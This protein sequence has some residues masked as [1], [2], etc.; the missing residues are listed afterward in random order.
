GGTTWTTQN[1]G[2]PTVPTGLPSDIEVGRCVHK[3]VLDPARPGVLYQQFHGGVFVS[4]D[5]AD[6]W[7]SIAD[8]L[9]GDFGFPM[10]ITASGDLFVMPLRS[11]EHRM[12][13]DGKLRVWR[14]RNQGRSWQALS[15]GLPNSPQYVGV[16]R[17][18]MA[19]D[20]LDP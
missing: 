17:D 12:M 2:L 6:S 13:D 1:K 8:G 18:A 10:V 9:P 5:G 19:V 16:L 4:E 14:S 3:M 20:P 11:D 15:N 7:R